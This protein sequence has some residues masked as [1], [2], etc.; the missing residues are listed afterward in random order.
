MI[1]TRLA[2]SSTTIFSKIRCSGDHS[3]SIG[4][5]GGP[6]VDTITT[7]SSLGTKNNILVNSTNGFHIETVTDKDDILYVS[8]LDAK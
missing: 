5:S 3:I 4:F 8:F 1:R 7:V 6:V 2:L